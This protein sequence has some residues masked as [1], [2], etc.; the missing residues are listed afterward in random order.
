[1]DGAGRD[2]VRSVGIQSAAACDLDG[3]PV[4]VTAC[5]GA[6]RVPYR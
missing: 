1:M 6:E 2:G 3:L 5:H 4:G